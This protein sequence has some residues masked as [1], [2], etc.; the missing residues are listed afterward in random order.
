[1]FNNRENMKN[2]AEDSYH[3]TSVAM[4]SS[5]LLSLDIKWTCV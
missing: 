2:I 1:M 4:L 3:K 5:G